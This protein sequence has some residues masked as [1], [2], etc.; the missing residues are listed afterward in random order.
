MEEIEGSPNF[1]YISFFNANNKKTLNAIKPGSNLI[2]H[3]F[4]KYFN[5]KQNKEVE[6]LLLK[7]KNSD[8]EVALVINRLGTD[9]VDIDTADG[10]SWIGC[11]NF[12]FNKDRGHPL[13]NKETGW[14]AIKIIPMNK[15]EF[16]CEYNLKY[17][18][19]RELYILEEIKKIYNKTKF[20]NLPI[21]YSYGL[22]DNVP[23]NAYTNKKLIKRI[24]KENS[25]NPEEEF[26]K[27]AM[28]ILT[29]VGHYDLKKWF[30]LFLNEKT[31][32]LEHLEMLDAIF[33]QVM[34][35]LGA[36]QRE[37][38]FVHYDLHY[39][40]VIVSD[41]YTNNLNKI[42]PYKIK[43]NVTFNKKLYSYP[44]YNNMLYHIW[45]FSRSFI[46]KNEDGNG[47]A[48]YNNIE[49]TNIIINRYIKECKRFFPDKFM[50]YQSEIIQNLQTNYKK[51]IQHI[52]CFDTY[53]LAKT[54]VLKLKNISNIIISSSDKLSGTYDYSGGSGGENTKVRTKNISLEYKI[55]L[56]KKINNLIA[57]YGDI[58]QMA[59]EDLTFGIAQQTPDNP[60]TNPKNVLILFK[61]FVTKK[62][63][64]NSVYA[65]IIN[66]NLDK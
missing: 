41:Y 33:F 47:K 49:F 4:K 65:K 27:Y 14:F 58:S 50:I 34:L 10:E 53:R 48:V 42:K 22:S 11:T 5:F 37:I 54:F 57:F 56:I 32:N 43:Y 20:V 23:I 29:F 25:V 39:G 3:N 28:S 61:K 21:L 55:K 26:G 30:K 51:Y 9:D 24:N 18:T 2:L 64:D 44:V 35:E 19:W 40:N 36:C 59:V 13:C 46:F 52:Q 6:F 16:N 7:V 63:S 15:D 62:S 31:I 45:D 8:K 66:I 17:K 1:D 60:I 12:K 38:P